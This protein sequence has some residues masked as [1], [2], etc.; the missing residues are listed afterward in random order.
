M[1]KEEI[2]FKVPSNPFVLSKL[3]PIIP[4]DRMNGICN[5]LE[6]VNHGLAYLLRC[7]PFD[8][9][10]QDKPRFSLR[11]GDDG[12]A[13]PFANDRIH[14]PVTNPLPLIDNLWALLNAHSFG[15]FSTPVITPIAFAA[16][17]LATQM[18][19]QVTSNTF[20]SQYILVD[21]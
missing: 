20:V 14:F 7:A 2:D 9:A 8:L 12:L 11:Q 3:F 5:R 15:Q 10:Q 6:Q 17:L 18:L 19:I 16:L 1:S 21:P 13:M 4:G